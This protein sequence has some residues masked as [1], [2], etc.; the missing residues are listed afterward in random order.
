MWPKIEWVDII[1]EYLSHC[2]SRQKDE[3]A[4]ENSTRW[5]WITNK[6]NIWIGILNK[7]C[8]SKHE[9][10]PASHL[11]IAARIT[12][13]DVTRL[14]NLISLWSFQDVMEMT[15]ADFYALPSWKQNQLRKKN[16]LFWK[17]GQWKWWNSQAKM[18]IATDN[19]HLWYVQL[20]NSGRNCSY[21]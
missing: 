18:I 10:V 4:T 9:L 21:R 5:N 11:A 7:T 16:G 13:L 20:C 2:A 6:I 14:L 19:I 15:K 12:C 1:D 8:K 3:I 17:T